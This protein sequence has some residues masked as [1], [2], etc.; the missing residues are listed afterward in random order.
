MEV[1]GIHMAL[2]MNTAILYLMVV[3]AMDT[4]MEL[5]VMAM[6]INM[7]MDTLMVM[8][9]AMDTLKVRIIVMMTILL[10]AW[11]DPANRFY[12]VYFYT[13]LQTR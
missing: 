4:V 12:K 9:I 10:K 11:V 13:L 6:N 5:M 2:G 8:A 1:M 7:P 3:L